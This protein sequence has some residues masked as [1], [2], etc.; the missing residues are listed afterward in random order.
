MGDF[1]RGGQRLRLQR[2]VMVLRGDFD[3]AGQ[4]VPDRVVAAV[5]AEF[6]P[7]A[8]RAGGE[9]EELVPE[10]DAEERDLARES[11]DCVDRVTERRGVG[12]AVRE[13]NAVRLQG[14]R[15]GR[16]RGGRQHGHA[17]AVLRHAAQDVV[18]DAEIE[19]GDVEIS[20]AVP[21][22]RFPGR[23]LRGVILPVEPCPGAG[24]VHRLGL[25]KRLVRGMQIRLL[26]AFV[27]Q[28]DGQAPGVDSGDAGLAVP[29]Q[30]SGERLLRA[31]VRRFVELVDHEAVQKQSAGFDILRIAAVISDFGGGQR[32]ELP[33]VGG[34]GQDLLITAHA[35]VEH[36]FSG[37]VDGG[38]EAP[39]AE[40]RAV[41]EREEGGALPPLFPIIH[42][43][44]P[45][46]YVPCKFFV[47]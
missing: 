25:R 19:G 10:A 37:R 24:A 26:A 14:E 36:R 9:A 46:K 39:A 29:F 21:L 12:R 7:P 8:L 32:D 34:V 4:Q 38:A 41:G 30:V 5:V 2:E 20:F 33:G 47:Q 42:I 6:Q 40:D 44:A 22:I 28:H 31:A 13:E 27:A 43:S 23:D 18:F 35:G 11:A 1:K 3:P 17:H 45:C 16:G 15:I